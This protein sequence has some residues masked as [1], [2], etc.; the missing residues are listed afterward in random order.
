MHLCLLYANQAIKSQLAPSGKKLLW[1]VTI[2]CKVAHN[3]INNHNQNHNKRKKR[4]SARLTE[5][6]GALINEIRK[7]VRKKLFGG[8]VEILHK[9]AIEQFDYHT[10]VRP[11]IKLPNSIIDLK[12]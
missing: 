12:M 2:Q 7:R 9:K 11:F 5:L 3:H 1:L 10:L 8:G 4:N 6:K